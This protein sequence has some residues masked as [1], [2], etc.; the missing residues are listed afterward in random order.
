M[1][2][3][4]GHDHFEGIALAAERTVEAAALLFFD[5]DGTGGVGLGIEID[6]KRVDFL[7]GESGGEV[8][9]GRGLADAAFLIGDGE[10]GGGHGEGLGLR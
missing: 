4:G 7:L 2:D 6:Q 9:G 10:N 3:G 1:I 5:A 8:D